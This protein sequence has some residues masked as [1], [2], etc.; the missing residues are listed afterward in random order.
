MRRSSAWV[1]QALSDFKTAE[2]LDNRNDP[3]TFCQAIAKYQQAVEKAVKGLAVVLRDGNVLKAGPSRHHPVE[4]L[5]NVILRSPRSNQNRDFMRRIDQIF[6]EPRVNDIQAMDALAP[7]YP[8]PGNP[9]ARNH[10]Y[11]FQDA[12]LNWQPPCAADAFTIGEIKRFHNTAFVVC[13]NLEEIV[14]ALEIIYPPPAIPW[15]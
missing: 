5:I 6:S 2:F 12:A 15:H 11:P 13:N 9:H 10:E 7:V 1:Q 8:D 4:P 14:T 3:R